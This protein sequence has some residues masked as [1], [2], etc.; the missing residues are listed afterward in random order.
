M[1]TIP[2]VVLMGMGVVFIG[3][4]SII[5]LTMAMSGVLREKPL[6]AG[7]DD[8]IPAVKAAKKQEED[9]QFIAAIFSVLAD[10][11]HIDLSDAK[12]TVEKV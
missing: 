2:F 9:L 7:K 5:F 4:T 10:D 1:Y 6:S 8:L 3:L 11:C 12:I